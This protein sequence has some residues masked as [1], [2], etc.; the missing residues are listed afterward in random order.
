MLKGGKEHKELELNNLL[1]RSFAHKSVS[2]TYMTLQDIH[3]WSEENLK[4]L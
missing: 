3:N 1:Q 2:S 4:L